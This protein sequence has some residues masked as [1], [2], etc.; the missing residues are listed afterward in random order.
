MATKTKA[1]YDQNISKIITDNKELFVNHNE[2]IPDLNYIKGS[3]LDYDWS[4]ASVVYSNS[5]IFSEE[6]FNFIFTKVQELPSGSF[7]INICDH[8]PDELLDGW[9]CINPFSRLMSWGTSEI[10]IYRKK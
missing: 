2:N 10:L 6:I 4:K 7:H 8:M 9:E 5:T 1:R 3:F